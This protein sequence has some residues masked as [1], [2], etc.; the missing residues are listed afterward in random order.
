MTA[1]GQRLEFYDA[2]GRWAGGR[3][4]LGHET[5]LLHD[6]IARRAVFIDRVGASTVYEW[7]PAGELLATIDA[8]GNEQRV[9]RD[10]AFLP[11][12]QTDGRNLTTQMTYD[13]RGNMLTVTHPD[14]RTEGF[15]YEPTFNRVLTHSQ[16]GLPSTSNTYDTAG[17]LKT[18]S[19]GIG[20]I[21]YSYDARGQLETVTAPGNAVQRFGYDSSGNLTTVTD[22]TNRTTTLGYD[23]A[24]HVVTTTDAAN[25]SRTLV[26]DAL[27]RLTSMRDELNHL[28][29]FTRDAAGMTLT[30][31][32]LQRSSELTRLCSR[33]VGRAE[34]IVTG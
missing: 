18:R 25:K 24:G 22:A 12:T 1:N 13:A 27:G 15:S 6:A 20:T 3:D 19:D 9:T 32:D 28:T 26:V 30:T 4:A 10:A 29:T 21:T 16:T 7:G 2:A 5:R 31:T 8:V 11:T 34:I 33:E 23:T 14:G 17:R